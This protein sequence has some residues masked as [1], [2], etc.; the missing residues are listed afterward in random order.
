MTYSASTSLS[1]LLASIAPAQK[2]SA[3]SDL[4]KF[5]QN[6]LSIP[7]ANVIFALSPAGNVGRRSTGE[8]EHVGVGKW[9]AVMEGDVYEVRSTP[10]DLSMWKL[11]GASV[12]LGLVQ[13]AKVSFGCVIP[14]E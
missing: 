3:V 10:L 11:G 12:A 6:G 5:I 13:Y 4:M 8:R 7:E 2:G 1:V 14:R 9:E